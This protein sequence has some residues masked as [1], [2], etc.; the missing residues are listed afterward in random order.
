MFKRKPSDRKL[1]IGKPI[2]WKPRT[3]KGKMPIAYDEVDGLPDGLSAHLH[4]SAS[5]WWYFAGMGLTPG[6][7]CSA[8]Y[9]TAEAA[10]IALEACISSHLQRRGES[11][12]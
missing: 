4:V 6:E 11:V 2:I 9:Q 5:G 3:A 7:N 10:L 12:S 8:E 1:S